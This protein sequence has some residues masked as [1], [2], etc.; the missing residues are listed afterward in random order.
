MLHKFDLAKLLIFTKNDVISVKNG[1]RSSCFAR[2]VEKWRSAKRGFPFL[3]APCGARYRHPF[4]KRDL[5]G[6]QCSYHALP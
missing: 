3:P 5:R 6:A 1:K 2:K 4:S